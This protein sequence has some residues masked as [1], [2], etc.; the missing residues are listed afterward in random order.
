MPEGPEVETVRRSLAPW[1]VGSRITALS[2][3][4]RDIIVTPADPPGGFS[5]QRT[6]PTRPRP[7]PRPDL[8]LDQTITALERHGK[9]LALIADSGRVLL[10]HLGMTG[11]LVVD[12]LPVPSQVASR[13]A[14]RAPATPHTHIQWNLS[15]PY[16]T[17]GT[18]S[19]LRLRFIDPRRFGGLWTLPTRDDLT[20]RWSSLG[21]D[22]TQ[23]TP[24]ALA[25][26]LASRSAPIKAALLD[27]A[28]VAG[29]GNI[30]ADE[31]L[32]LARLHP[33]APAASLS[34]AQL[35]AL[36]HAIRTVIHAA[37]D[38]RGSTIRDY[39]DSRGQPGTAQLTHNVYARAGLPCPRCASPLASATIAQRTTV[40][41]PNCQT[42]PCV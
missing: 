17:P 11:K 1:L 4:R 35:A 2:L 37:I 25:A 20:L 15:T 3:R 16:A 22:A 18:P 36:A 33:R 8:L 41:C 32:F 23:I 30:Y 42:Q 34:P 12:A 14:A 40:W 13:R 31:S 26:S 28:I 9:Q 27:Q 7:V 21:P 19:T 38:A 6:I 10:V 24:A 29:V 39:T 5:R